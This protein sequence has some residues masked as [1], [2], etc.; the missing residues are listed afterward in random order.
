MGQVQQ[1]PDWQPA[2][3]ASGRRPPHRRARHLQVNIL[4]RI[5]VQCYN[6]K[7][8]FAY[9]IAKIAF[10]LIVY[11]ASWCKNWIISLVFPPIFYRQY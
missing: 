10:R 11:T 8:T 4:F 5:W 7:D 6:F 9:K 1:L 2:Q 3:Q